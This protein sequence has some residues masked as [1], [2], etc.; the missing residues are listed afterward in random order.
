[1]GVVELARLKREGVVLEW[2]LESLVAQ[3][4]NRK[5]RNQEPVSGR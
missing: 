2:S 3:Y 1:M 5:T 4:F